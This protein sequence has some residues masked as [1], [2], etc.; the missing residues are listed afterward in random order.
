MKRQN[1]AWVPCFAASAA[2]LF[3]L[4]AGPAKAEMDRNQLWSIVSFKCMRHLAK[5]EAAIPCDSIDTT[6]GWD[7]G[8]AYLKDGVGIARMLAIPTH[9]VSG[10]EDPAVLA[11]DEPNYFAAAWN[12]Q[13]LFPMRLH[14]VAPSTSVGVVVD[15]KV[16]RDQDQL[17]VI[18]DCLKPEV[19]ASLSSEAGNVKSRW[20]M[21]SVPLNGRTYWARRVDATDPENVW[22][23]QL[24]VDDLPGAKDALAD[25]SLALTQPASLKGQGFLILADRVEGEQGGRPRDLLDP[26]CA[27]VQP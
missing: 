2:A 3:S 5:A 24:L 11:K 8:I 22:P 20:A 1:S 7:R 14:A 15:A 26:S 25:W 19:A 9:P 27:V 18:V 4:L 21:M 12:A 10:I 17:H 16:A 6:K 13:G 23:L